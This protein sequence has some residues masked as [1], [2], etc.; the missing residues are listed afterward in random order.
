MDA[1]ILKEKVRYLDPVVICEQMHA[2]AKWMKDDDDHLK[3]FKTKKLKDKKQKR[4]HKE[5]MKRVSAYIS[6]M[7]ERWED[8]DVI[9]ALYHI[10]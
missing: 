5:T 4:F 3:P 8:I 7:I 1:I 2:S 9:Y 6:L 10:Q